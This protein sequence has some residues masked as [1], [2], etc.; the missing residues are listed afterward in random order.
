M[1]LTTLDWIIVALSLGVTFVPAIVLARRAGR[2]ITGLRLK[3]AKRTDLSV[4]V[5]IR[6][7]EFYMAPSAT[8]IDENGKH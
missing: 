6:W 2:N 8:T 4:S 3:L 7:D 5:V 1:H